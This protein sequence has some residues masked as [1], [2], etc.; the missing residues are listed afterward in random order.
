M[1]FTAYFDEVVPDKFLE[2]DLQGKLS[3]EDYERFGPETERTI[4]E[5]GRIRVLVKMIG[6]DGWDAGALWED[7]DW[8][9][10]H[11][12]H[13]EQ[14]AI[15]GEKTWHPWMTGFC[16]PFTSAR[17]RYFTHEQL[18]EARQWLNASPLRHSESSLYWTRANYTG[19]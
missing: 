10:R 11:F 9:A 4:H 17:V 1:N 13:I 19:G 3:R 2:F 5:H 16:R 14:L 8:K 18:D 7:I 6:F 12:N 15:V